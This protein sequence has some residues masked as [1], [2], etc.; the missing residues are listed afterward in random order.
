MTSTKKMTQTEFERFLTLDLIP[1]AS[2]ELPNISAIIL[3]KKNK[4]CLAA[5][6]ENCG[7]YIVE[8]K[9]YELPKYI[10]EDITG[11]LES[12]TG[13]DVLHMDEIEE[14]DCRDE[15]EDDDD[16]DDEDEEIV[17]DDDSDDDYSAEDSYD[18]G[19]IQYD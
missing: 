10:E 13:L 14:C 17:Y 2:E 7:N 5:Q 1:D 15:L 11:Y 4:F 19:N 6:C 9:E 12:L 3:K 16:Y 8:K 18:D